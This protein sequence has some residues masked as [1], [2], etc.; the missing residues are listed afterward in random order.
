[1]T[2]LKELYPDCEDGV[3]RMVLAASDGKIGAAKMSLA[4]MGF[5]PHGK[6]TVRPLAGAVASRG[7]TF[8]RGRGP[9]RASAT[10][11]L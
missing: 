5:R 10:R 8:V 3:L 2:K 7:V 11:A 1:M 4:E 9:H 6:T